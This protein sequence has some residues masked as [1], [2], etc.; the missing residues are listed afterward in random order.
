MSNPIRYFPLSLLLVRSTTTKPYGFSQ[1]NLHTF[2]N[3]SFVISLLTWSLYCRGGKSKAINYL[4]LVAA[5][6]E[7]HD[8]NSGRRPVEQVRLTVESI[9]INLSG[10][11]WRM[12]SEI[13]L[14]EHTDVRQFPWRHAYHTARASRGWAYPRTKLGHAINSW[15]DGR[16]EPSHII[17]RHQHMTSD[18]LRPYRDRGWVARLVEPGCPE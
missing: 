15:A 11:I 4:H 12:T 3:S 8:R 6:V 17:W 1:A 16:V 13:T 7:R 5:I 9:P 10:H 2:L 14:S 18:L